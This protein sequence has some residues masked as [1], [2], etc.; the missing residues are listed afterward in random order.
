MLANGERQVAPE[1]SGIRRDHVARYEWA[2]RLLAPES[3][4]IDLACG[5]G[6]GAAILH[7]A[8]HAVAAFDRSAFAIEYARRHYHCR[9]GIR[10]G[11][12]DANELS[13]ASTFD[14]AVCFETVEH[15]EDPLPMLRELCRSAPILFA[16]VPNERVFP[17]EGRIKFHY[18][19]Y[20]R[21]E[22]K[23]LLERA[24]YRVVAWFGQAGPE[25]EV[26]PDIEGRTLIAHAV[27]ADAAVA[28]KFPAV[29]EPAAPRPAI[30]AQPVPDH[31]AI[32]GLGPSCVSL[33]EMTRR[34]GGLSAYCDEVWGLNAIGDVLRC[35]RI[36]HMDDMRVQE[37]RAA[38]KPDSNIAA[39]VAWLRDNPGPVYTSIVREG[40]PGHVAFP[41]EDVLNASGDSN[42]GAPYFNST[43][44]YAIAYA[45]HI[46]VK[47][48]SLFGLDYTLPNR[49]KAEQG[50][51][52]CEFWLGIAAARGIQITIPEMSSLMDGCANDRDRLYGYDCVDV[53]FHDLPGGGL[54]V[55]FVERATPSAEEVEKRYDHTQHPNPLMRGKA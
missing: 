39:M 8:G 38:A 17:H 15:I 2:A 19:H 45:I 31:V 50:R 52:C 32:V 34:L 43:A 53:H 28:A 24:G 4:V 27:R 35:D 26:E 18:R 23:A 14:A 12:A 41:L 46:G 47:R 44:A 33:F 7:D 51:A 36:F 13:L 21:G 1:L 29:S 11:V 55:E 9:A 48:I 3:R 25:S 20:T 37:A 54:K 10:Y 30:V 49:H 16:S 6:Y 42:G 5:V 22:F 40:Y